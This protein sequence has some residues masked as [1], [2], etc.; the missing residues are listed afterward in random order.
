ML[1]T[2]DRGHGNRRKPKLLGEL[3]NEPK[4]DAK[5]IGDRSIEVKNH[6]TI[7]PFAQGK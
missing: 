2:I 1:P 7:H 5:T 6:H 4:S 3:I